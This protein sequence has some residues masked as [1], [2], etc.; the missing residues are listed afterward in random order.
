[1]AKSGVALAG[2]RIDVFGDVRAFN[3]ACGVRMNAESGSIPD[4]DLVPSLQ[5]IAEELNELDEAVG[6][7]NLVEVADAVAD[8][9]YV[10]SGMLLRLGM[11]A[12]RLLRSVNPI[13]IPAPHRQGMW[14]LAEGYALKAHRELGKMFITS[15]GCGDVRRHAGYAAKA[16]RELAGT[17]GIPLQ[18]V[19]DEVQRSNMAKVVEG[20]VVRD[21]VTNKILK[22]DG[23][24]AP[25]IA[26]VLERAG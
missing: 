13:G 12:P 20:V 3:E 19:W 25:D 8:L 22:P 6:Q 11:T 14:L 15:F 16:L 1:M 7:R 9:I 10:M 5:L 23:W 24:T 26:G 2:E 18:A 17:L 21:P 4:S